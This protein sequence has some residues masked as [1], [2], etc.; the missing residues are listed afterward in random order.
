[1]IKTSFA[2]TLIILIIASTFISTVQAV[3]VIKSIPFYGPTVMAYNPYKGAVWITTDY[4]YQPE[5]MPMNVTGSTKTVSAI[6][7]KTYTVL[8]NIS[9]GVRPLGI[10]YDSAH[11]ELYVTSGGENTIVVISDTSNSVVATID[12][13]STYGWLTSIVYDS[14]KDEMFVRSYNYGGVL[15]ISCSTK[16]VVASIPLGNY[17]ALKPSA[18]ETLTYDSGKGEIYASYTTLSDQNPRNFI[19]VI[20]DTTNSVVATIPL[21]NSITS[22][23]AYDLAT[24]EIYFPQ[25]DNSSLLVISDETHTITGSI[26][27]EYAPFC[28]AYDPVKD[29]LFAGANATY[30]ISARTRSIIETVPIRSYSMVYDSGKNVMITIGNASIQ[31]I[32]DAS[33]PSISPTSTVPEYPALAALFL[34]LLIPFICVKIKRKIKREDNLLG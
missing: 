6:S 31:F 30:I 5:S 13:N 27:L 10:A 1:L 19:S 21:D 28:V 15:V 12:L 29:V 16:Q 23:G 2:L 20:S 32:S 3:E 4:T 25:R 26:P 17:S 22:P 33:L 8:A 14:G 34:L 18:Y 9:V 24:G 7:D 11:R